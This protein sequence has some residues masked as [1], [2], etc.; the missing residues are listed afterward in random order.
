[1]HVLLQL[2]EKTEVV[3]KA[4]QKH[5]LQVLLLD[6][7]P[8]HHLPFSLWEAKKSSR[9]W[10]PGNIKRMSN[11]ELFS[12]RTRKI[13][14]QRLDGKNGQTQRSTKFHQSLS[15]LK[16]VI[17]ISV[18]LCQLFARDRKHGTDEKESG[19][20]RPEFQSQFCDSL[21]LE[22][23]IFLKKLILY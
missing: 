1:M 8:I 22:S 3:S 13:N 6:I 16:K 11:P 23:Y 5:E 7:F 4:L 9:G 2:D 20:K 15:S 21:A 12:S 14:T 17:A 10:G 19:D 18:D